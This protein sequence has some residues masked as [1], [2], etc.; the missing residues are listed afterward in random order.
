MKQLFDWLREQINEEAFP[1]HENYSAVWHDD[2]M[3]TINEAEAKWGGHAICY[4][5]SPCEYQNEDIR[6]ADEE[7]EVCEL[8]DELVLET[9]QYRHGV[10]AFR[11]EE[12]CCEYESCGH[13]LVSAIKDLLVNPN[14]RFKKISEVE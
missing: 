13:C 5:D 8:L 12:E 10:C 9:P 11:H 3:N 6:V 7:A 4:L 14:S 1:T 2:V